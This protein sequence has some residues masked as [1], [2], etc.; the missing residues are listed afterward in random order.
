MPAFAASEWP[1]KEAASI[2]RAALTPS[3]AVSDLPL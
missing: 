2:T 1:N 3:R